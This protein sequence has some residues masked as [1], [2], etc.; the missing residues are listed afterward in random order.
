MTLSELAEVAAPKSSRSTSA[1]DRPRWVASQAIAAPVTPPPTTTTSNSR[2]A[3]AV[4]FLFTEA[5]QPYR[6]PYLARRANPAA[7]KQNPRRG[8]GQKVYHDGAGDSPAGA[9]GLDPREGVGDERRDGEGLEHAPEQHDRRLG[10]T[11]GA[12]R[13]NRHPQVE[14]SPGRP[15]EHR[16]PAFGSAPEARKDPVRHAHDELQ[17]PAVQQQLGVQ[18]AELNHPGSIGMLASG[19]KDRTQRYPDTEVHQ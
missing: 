8:R 18:E 4:R 14:Q 16:M 2:P 1:T 13:R 17:R 6:I 12:Q 5:L 11:H 19:E 10:A 15:R 7:R 3:S 9:E